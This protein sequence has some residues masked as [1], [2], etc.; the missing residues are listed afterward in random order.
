MNLDCNQIPH[1]IV[2]TR[3]RQ[4][5]I[6]RVENDRSHDFTRDDRT[7]EAYSFIKEREEIDTK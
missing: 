5:F 7:S 4:T 2:L 1:K 6:V 3:S